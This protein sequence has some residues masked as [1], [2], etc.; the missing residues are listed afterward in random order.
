VLG[1]LVEDPS[2]LEA[3]ALA[4]A[5]RVGRTALF[6]GAFGLL[7]ALRADRER[8]RAL[9]TLGVVGLGA[10]DLVAVGRTV[11]PLAP[12]ELVS[13]RP[14]VVDVLAPHAEATRVHSLTMP[15]CA[16]VT[17]A[18]AGWEPSWSAALASVDAL[19]PP[20]GV[21]WGLFGSFDGQFTGLEPRALLPFLPAAV[22]LSGTADGLRLLQVANVGHVVRLG[23]GVV[24][25]LELLEGRAT[26]PGCERQLLRVPEPLPRAYVVGAERRAS[27]TGDGVAA[28]L[29]SAFDPRRS[30]L[31]ADAHAGGGDPGPVGEARVTSRRADVVE[32]EAVL[33]RPGVLVLVEA[34]DPGWRVSVDGRGAPLLAANVLFRAVRLPEGRHRVRF[35]YRPW[36][37]TTGV[38]LSGLGAVATIAL[39]LAGWRREARLM[40][41]PAAGSIPAREE[42]P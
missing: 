5:L 13:H 24:P 12:A 2:A 30:V 16:R 10:L 37:A 19:R 21:R 9:T 20:S 6:F 28:L 34:Y 29:D 39:G 22:R 3:P 36:T 40:I 25:G 38:L 1:A 33:V 32:I 31:L 11:N 41:A 14:A 23:R 42:G 7:L 18:R 27:D 17:E 35:V 8:A 26:G 15:G 4:A